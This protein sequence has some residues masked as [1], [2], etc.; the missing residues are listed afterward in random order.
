MSGLNRRTHWLR[1]LIAIALIS[2]PA[3]LFAQTNKAEEPKP[4]LL[5]VIPDAV[6]ANETD[7]VCPLYPVT[8]VGENLPTGD[9]LKVFVNDRQSRSG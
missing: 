4:K 9:A 5:K 7:F 3:G 1:G 8:V 6:Y 2:L